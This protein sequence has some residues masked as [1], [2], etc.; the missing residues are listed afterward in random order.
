MQW[1]KKVIIGNSITHYWGGEPSREN[2]SQSWHHQMKPA[3]FFN[4][5]YGWDKIENV[6]WRVYHGELDGYEA[7]EV[8]LLIGTN[9][10]G[11]NTHDEIVEGL[12]FLLNQIEIRQPKANI[13]VVGLLPRRGKES[14]IKQ[15]N[16]QISKMA[17]RNNYIF[18]DVGDKLLSR[19]DV[20]DETL[21]L[22]GLHPNE[23]GY[24]LIV[25]DIIKSSR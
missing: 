25:N 9:N 16:E 22:D 5:G 3:G 6:L 2:G 7:D 20:I 8:V 19:N 18:L 14:E 21:F 12:Q 4:L 10:L 17:L 23:K 24:S 13:K 11:A 15:I 1:P